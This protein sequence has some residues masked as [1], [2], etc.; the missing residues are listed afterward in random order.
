MR[1]ACRSSNSRKP[2][3]I[4][5]RVFQAH[6]NRSRSIVLIEA[7]QGVSTSSFL[8]PANALVSIVRRG[9]SIEIARETSQRSL[10][11]P[12]FADFPGTT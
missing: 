2:G 6:C 11:D 10:P 9:G 3:S 7:H 4:D 5:R 1:I 12:N 8:N